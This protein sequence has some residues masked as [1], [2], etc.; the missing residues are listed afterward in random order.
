MKITKEYKFYYGHRNQ[1]LSDKCYR[2]HGHDAK[3]FVTFN[4]ERK[5]NLTTLFG[6]FDSK[7]EPWFKEKFDHRFA[8]DKN[9]PL[10]PYL[11]K[12]ETDGHGDLGLNILPFATSV[13]NV[14][15][16]IFHHITKVFGFDV[17]EIKYQ[18]TRTSTV[19]YG[20]EDY[21]RDLEYF[22]EIL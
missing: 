17:E 7:I 13:E 9:D 12:Y 4:V 3:I 15:L 11:Q 10:L 5:G 22:K 20:K 8:I 18:E 1:E 2:P 14:T 16:Y 19:V 21:K 6:D